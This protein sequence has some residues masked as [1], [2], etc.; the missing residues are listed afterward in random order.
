MIGEMKFAGDTFFAHAVRSNVEGNEKS[1]LLPCWVLLAVTYTVSCR[2][3]AAPKQ[4][5]PDSKAAAPPLSMP[6]V[7]APAADAS[8]RQQPTARNSSGRSNGADNKSSTIVVVSA[9]ISLSAFLAPQGTEGN[10]FTVVE[11]SL[12][13][14]LAVR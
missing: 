9:D 6:F 7:R 4:P 11:K 5:G 14:S 1:E 3:I 13:V 8:S 10:D 12:D 2:V